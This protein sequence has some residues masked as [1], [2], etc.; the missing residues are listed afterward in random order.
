[1]ILSLTVILAALS[2]RHAHLATLGVPPLAATALIA[3]HEF[4]ELRDSRFLPRQQ[5]VGGEHL[6]HEEA[7]TVARTAVIDFLR[8]LAAA[9]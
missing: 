4:Q 2:E 3:R 1:V 9:R 8:L 5:K 6:S 7:L